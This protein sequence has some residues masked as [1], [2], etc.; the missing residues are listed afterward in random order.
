MIIFSS[1]CS[2][3]VVYIETLV[4]FVDVNKAGSSNIADAYGCIIIIES[5][6]DLPVSLNED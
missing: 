2:R 6:P 5:L 4:Y 3:D 1:S